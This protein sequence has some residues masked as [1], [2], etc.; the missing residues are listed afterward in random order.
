ME[1][2]PDK[3]SYFLCYHFMKSLPLVFCLH[4]ATTLVIY[5]KLFLCQVHAMAEAVSGWPGSMEAQVQSQANPHGIC[6]ELSGTG[7]GFSQGTVVF[8]CQYNSIGA[9]FSFILF[10]DAM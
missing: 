3:H 10:T 4:A 6:G 2:F 8:P 7:T 5:T 9:L 1:H